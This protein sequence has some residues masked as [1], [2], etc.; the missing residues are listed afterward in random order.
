M[1][2]FKNKPVT[3]LN[4]IY[5]YLVAILILRL[6]LVFL[7]TMPTGGDMGAHVVPI[8]YFIENFALNFQLNGWSNDW[9]A[10]YP[11]YFFYF[12][13]PAVVTFLL[14][15]VFPYGV[16]F[17]LMVI[18]SILL[19]IYS[20]ERLFRNM[21]SNFSIFGYIAGLTYILTESFTIYGG[22]LASTLAGQFS[23]TYSIAFAN[24]AIAHLTKSDKNNRHVVSAIFL[25]FSLLSHLIPFLIYALIY[26]YFWIKAKNTT[27]EKFSSGLIFLFITIRF[28]TSLLTNLEYTTNMSYTPFTKLSDLVKSDITPYILVIFIILLFNMKLVMS[29]KVTSLFEWFIVIF[30]VLLYFYVPEG[31]LWNGRVV[32]FLNLGVIIIFFKLFEYSVMNIFRYEQGEIILKI[33]STIILF[34]YLLTFVDKWNISGYKI[35]LYPLIS[36]LTFG[37]VYFFSSSVNLFKLTFTASIIFTVS[38]LPYWVS[39][40]FN[41]YENKDQWGD[42]ENLYSS[43]NTLSPGRIMWEPNSDLNKYGTPMVLM[44]IPLYTHHSSMEGLYFDSSITTPFHFIAVSGLAERPSNPVGG[45]RYI[46]NNFEKGQEYLEDLGVDYFVSYTD[47]ITTKAIENDKLEFLFTSEPFTVFSVESEKV[48]LVNQE[49]VAFEKVPFIDRTLSSLFRNTEYDNFFAEAYENFDELKTQRIIELP[50]VNFN[51]V[52]SNEDVVNISNF[53]MTSNSIS[54]ITDRP[55]ELHMIK[56]SYFPNWEIENGDGPYRI[57]PSFMAVIPNSENVELTFIRTGIE[58]YSFYT[59]LASLLLY[60]SLSKKRKAVE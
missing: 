48:E 2:L 26:F 59:A 54:F 57:S 43:L 11:L 15:L 32:S 20:F 14:N 10:G 49:L 23:F 7:N 35:F 31:A 46:N 45:L 1:K 39:W 19:T 56:T 60:V 30:S 25:G 47:S 33:L 36:V 24:L 28:T 34:S 3:H 42:I 4:Q 22:N 27:V 53:N 40:N 5:F 9:F 37:F 21:Q 52:S 8:K 6:D 51:I 55:N 18:G 41:G 38:F 12:P 17:K 16:A 50:S 13:F 58:T 29:F 44:T